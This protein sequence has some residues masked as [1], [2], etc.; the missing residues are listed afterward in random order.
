MDY[1]KSTL[2]R[3][4]LGKDIPS[5]PYNL[6]EKIDA[7]E[8]ESIWSLHHGTKKEDGSPVSIFTFDCVK[9]KEKLPL[10]KNA[11]K[12]FRTIR[13]PDLLS[14]IDGV[15]TD[16]Y[17]YIVT[18]RV[19]PLKNQLSVRSDDNSILWGLYKVGSAL[20]FLNNDCAHIH[21][22]IRISS[23]F[24]NKAGEWKLAGFE[25]MS[26]LKDDGQVICTYGGL[27][28]ESSSSK[29]AP[30]EVVK[31]NS[32]NV[33]KD[34]DIWVTDSWHYG[35]LIYE[36]YN[37]ESFT[38]VSQLENPGSI[39]Q[40]MRAAYKQL[41]NPNPKSRLN[42][43]NFID[44][45]LRVNGY[46]QND[47]IQVMLFLENMNIKEAK[48]KEIFFKKLD[49][50]IN[51][52]SPYICKYKILPEL[53]NALEFGS[54]GSKVLVP[55][56]KIGNTLDDE[57]YEAVIVIAIVKMFSVP[58]R[59][60]RLSL[61]ENLSLFIDRL[62]NKTVNDKVFTNVVTGFTDTA[63]II[64]ENT[65][66]S[67]LLL[68]PKL[69]DR[70]INNDLL[71]Y[72]AKLQMDNEPGIR[73]N[74]TICLGKISKYLNEST[75]KKVLVP[76]FTRALRDPFPHAKI[77][78]LMALTAT[79]EY[80]DASECATK[81]LPSVSMVLIEKE[82]SVRLQAFKTLDVFVK[83]LEKLVESM[84]DSAATEQNS[85]T[86][87]SVITSTTT[88]IASSVVGAAT[89][90]AET[91]TGWA[92]TSLTKKFVGTAVEGEISPP[93]P[94]NNATI[95]TNVNTNTNTNTNTNADIQIKEKEKSFDHSDHEIS[96]GWENDESMFSID[97][98]D[99]RLNGINNG[100]ES[101]KPSS[102]LSENNSSG[103]GGKGLKLGAISPM[104]LSK[105][106]PTDGWGLDDSGWSNEFNEGWDDD[107]NISRPSS[108]TPS[109][110]STRSE[111]SESP[112]PTKPSA[113]THQV[114]LT[115]EEKQAEIERKRE[116]R[117]QRMAELKDKKKK[118]SSL[119]VK[120]L[121]K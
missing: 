22:N 45:G 17:I 76:A 101:S 86:A 83:R 55:I 120:K 1:L 104:K 94:E 12:K 117:R 71:R 70:V 112:I 121:E 59:A 74:T 110:N 96:D 18:E 109:T 35:I 85:T 4:V 37:N 97:P 5:F 27:L 50:S 118:V 67:I 79:S 111:S 8:G 43:L 9:Q 49:T 61:L 57:E 75:R 6:V 32:W 30:P 60:I 20:K 26:S 77:A 34:H 16:T 63:P 39:P 13:H 95:T 42:I 89:S 87:T 47:L 93:S 33:L 99:K 102:K 119:G 65:I 107:W 36:V 28:Y 48:E 81:I 82:K 92:V 103:G 46:F 115:K 56:L 29:Y 106:H 114:L 100:W 116:E 53:V 64:R 113:V 54:G 98:N 84:P 15:E 73:T 80:F 31:S 108:T 40:V 11:F 2:S 69:S 3:V 25:L 105:T 78:S 66:K 72:L 91:W 7:Y 10:A 52:F 51:K 21:G 19:E 41:I 23:I 38:S 88:T 24:T 58:D 90:T 68:A 14:Y 62:D 44:I